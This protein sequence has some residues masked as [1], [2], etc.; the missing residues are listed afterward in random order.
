MDHIGSVTEL[1]TAQGVSAVAALGAAIGDDAACRV[2][3]GSATLCDIALASWA[4]GAADSVQAVVQYASKILGVVIEG[5]DGEVSD[6]Q[7]A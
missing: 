3:D 4:V 5:A 6:S 2:M 7:C 1:M